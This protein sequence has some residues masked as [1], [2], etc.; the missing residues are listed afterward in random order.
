MIID[1][2]LSILEQAGCIDIDEDNR[3]LIST[4]IGRIASYYYLSHQT[5]HMF[6]EKLTPETKL[7]QLLVI[8]C[9]ATEYAELPVRHNEDGI[10]G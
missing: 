7:E 5:V 2:S 6:K 8:L 9:N 4:T 3:T 1:G 10:N